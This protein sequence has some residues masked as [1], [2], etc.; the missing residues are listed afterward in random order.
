MIVKTMELPAQ[1]FVTIRDKISMKDIGDF[2]GKNYGLIGG[3]LQVAG[4][5]PIGMP[6]A[7]YYE[8]DEEG[9]MTDMAAAMPVETKVNLGESVENVELPASKAAIIDYYG[10]YNGIGAAHYAMDEYLNTYNLGLSGPVMEQ[11]ITDPGQEPDTAKWHTQVVYR[12]K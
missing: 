2:L 6:C 7:L 9:G 1:N 10:D 8:W 4:V 12:L 5:E 11:Y 3:A